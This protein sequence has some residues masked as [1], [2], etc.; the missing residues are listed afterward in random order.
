[1]RS[2]IS[3]AGTTRLGGFTLVEILVALFIFAIIG[4]IGTQLI[5]R[6]TKQQTLLS[7]RGARVVEIQRAMQVMKRDFMQITQRPIRDG[8]GDIRG[9]LILDDDNQLE[10][11]RLGW[12][13]PLR[14]PR[15]D[16]QRVAYQFNEQDKVL[17]RL[18]WPV[19]DRA[20]DSEPVRQLLLSD[21][22]RV[23]FSII[24]SDGSRSDYWPRVVQ[25]TPGAVQVA[26]ILVRFE[27]PPYGLLERIW[28]VP[29][30]N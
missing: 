10:F 6:V 17:A 24:G 2:F 14:Q 4:L 30:V 7:E 13:N 9:A 3:S 18:F 16:E 29:A 28:E 21:V 23:E 19:L 1:M 22:E 27:M 12:R 26:A 5:G 25:S 8:L 15:S 20:Q 11:S